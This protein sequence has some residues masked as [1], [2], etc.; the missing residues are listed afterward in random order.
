MIYLSGILLPLPKSMEAIALVSPA[1]HLDQLLFRVL[2]APSQGT[3]WVHIAVLAGM[4]LVLTA[5]SVRRLA[6]VG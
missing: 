1:Y 2:G 4:T 5:V 3:A 6:R